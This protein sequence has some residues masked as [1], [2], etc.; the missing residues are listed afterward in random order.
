MITVV[1]VAS[2]VVA[3]ALSL[4]G[5]YHIYQRSNA[6]PAVVSYEALPPEK[7]VGEYTLHTLAE[8]PA[9][10]I[11]EPETVEEFELPL[12]CAAEE[13]VEADPT[14]APVV[15]ATPETVEAPTVRYELTDAERAVV[16]SVVMAESGGESFEGQMAVAQCI[17]NGCEELDLRPDRVVIEY[18]YTPNR[19]QPSQS[20]KDAVTAVF[21]KGEVAVEDSILWFYAP[22]G[23]A[24]LPWHESQRYVCSI[25]GHKFFAKW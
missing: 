2:T 6:L 12:T 19:P 1:A 21:D 15:E 4:L 22:A 14:D 10:V 7:A 3:F 17:L 25:G 18:Q 13:E 23:V 20:V 5:A 24:G 11:T 16:E 9:E 8:V